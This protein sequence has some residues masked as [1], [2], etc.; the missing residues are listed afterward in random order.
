[1]IHAPTIH[2]FP[3]RAFQSLLWIAPLDRVVS[4]DDLGTDRH[5]HLPVTLSKQVF[6]DLRDV[7]TRNTSD[8]PADIVNT[9]RRVVNPNSPNG[10]ENVLIER[11]M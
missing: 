6:L 7:F 1:M 3:A 10:L 4:F 8:A 11:V 2:W 5:L 9:Q